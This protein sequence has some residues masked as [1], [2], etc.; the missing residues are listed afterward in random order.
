[1]SAVD[2]A[3]VTYFLHEYL[4]GRMMQLW[5][6]AR[7]RTPVLAAQLV[8]KLQQEDIDVVMSFGLNMSNSL[9]GLLLLAGRGDLRE[10]SVRTDG[11]RA[12]ADQLAAV[13]ENRILLQQ[14]T[15]ALDL[16]QSQYETSSRV[17]GT[18]GPVDVL[19]AISDFAGGM[20]SEA[21]LV[22]TEADGV[23]RIIARLD[24]TGGR[25]TSEEI[26]MDDYPASQTLNV[27]EA[28]EVRD[29]TVDTFLSENE[30]Q[31]L[32]AADIR[33][34]VLL[35]ILKDYALSGL[36][37]L[38]DP[39]PNHVSTERLRAMRSL[40]DQVG[41]VLENRRL[42]RS[43]E[44]SLRESQQ[45]Y[46]ANRAMLSTRDNM[47]VLRTLK[48]Q[49][50]TDA[51]VICQVDIEY[52]DGEPVDLVLVYELT[53]D[54]ERQTRKYLTPPRNEMLETSRYLQQLKLRGTVSFA[55]RYVPVPGNPV[56]LVEDRYNIQSY[57]L[58]VVQHQSRI[59][60]LVM[61]LF[62]DEHVFEDSARRLYEAIGDQ[63][64]IAIENQ[65][66]LSESQ[67]AAR[68]M[69]SQ[70]RILESIGRY[71]ARINTV[72]DEA[73]LLQMGAQTLVETL[74]VD[75]CGVVIFNDDDQT[76]TV[77]GEFP[78]TDLMGTIVSTRS[79]PVLHPDFNLDNLVFIPD[80]EA[81]DAEDGS[82]NASLKADL[83]GTGIKSVLIMPLVGKDGELIG[84]VGLDLYQM[85]RH[86]TESELNTART[87]AAQMAVGLQNIRLLR[88]SRTRAEQLQRITDF[89]QTAQTTL[90]LDEMIGAALS[91]V[92]RLIPVSHIAVALYDE[93][94]DELYIAGGWQ[95]RNGER[96]RIPASEPVERSLTTT[97]Y[98][99][100]TGKYLYIPDMTTTT[101]A[102]YPHAADIVTLLAMPLTNRNRT[103]GVM[104]IGARH[105][106]AYTDTDIALFQQMVNQ[107]AVAID[108]AR[109]YTQSQRVAENK[110]LANEI[111]VQLQRQNDINKMIDLTMK[112]V[113]RAIGANRGR[114][115]LNA[116]RKDHD[117]S[118]A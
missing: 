101:Q 99:F 78:L 82:A 16:I 12:I 90:N 55:L 3:R 96:Q 48:H 111:S 32:L 86:F 62:D 56:R 85:G 105:A 50:T 64:Q 59:S 110:T 52:H 54:M 33:S 104:T 31:K 38:A 24:H 108:N 15:D 93:A 114:I 73:E 4:E 30:R 22:T 17:F 95:E 25:L 89:S 117:D 66:L 57:I 106:Q 41:V 112:E 87:I 63:V 77:T 10:Q 60:S 13:I 91:S 35:P 37:M 51:S 88:D 27:L 102:E 19:R 2:D 79:N 42:M 109:A 28:L 98:V 75:H 58:V 70:V 40:A 8:E 94:H 113:G 47:E 71:A 100:E 76:G 20:F 65:K 43:K 11:M 68:E 84:S 49:V 26:S 7:P 69:A 115:R 83:A 39:T 97:G 80:V 46:E 74:D 29:V 18:S 1:V 67:Q 21:Q 103:L 107:M 9:R 34:L 14:A 92:P 72:S 118:Q 23:A 5:T 61:L 36:V 116:L 53:P 44:E 6:I 81:I 45:L